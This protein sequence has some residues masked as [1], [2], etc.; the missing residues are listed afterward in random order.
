LPG[1]DDGLVLAGD[2][3]LDGLEICVELAP[4]S[5]RRLGLIVGLR[6]RLTLWLGVSAA[7][8]SGSGFGG[9]FP[10]TAG[11]GGRTAH[12]GGHR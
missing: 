4:P 6:P 3:A 10:G 7:L 1:V 12:R 8:E 2:G 9:C 5:G 11:A